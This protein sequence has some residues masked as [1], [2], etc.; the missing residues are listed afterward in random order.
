M[1]SFKLVSVIVRCGFI[2]ETNAEAPDGHFG[3]FVRCGRRRDGAGARQRRSS[4]WA[5][6]DHRIRSLEMGLSERSDRGFIIER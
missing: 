3:F 5:G 6:K 4:R 2:A 1:R